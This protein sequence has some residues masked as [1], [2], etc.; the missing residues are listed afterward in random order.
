M[1]NHSLYLLYKGIVLNRWGRKGNI[2]LFLA[3]RCGSTVITDLLS[4][5][6]EVAW[7][8][9]I[10]NKN[11]MKY[12]IPPDWSR[13][14]VKKTILWHLYRKRIS[15]VGFETT[16]MPSQQLDP[17]IIGMTM[18][19]YIDLLVRIGITHFIILKRENHWRRCISAE[20]MRKKELSHT[21]ETIEKVTKLFVDIQNTQIGRASMPLLDIFKQTDER[22]EQLESILASYRTLKLTYEADVRDDPHIAYDKICNFL[23]IEKV[24]VETDYKKT[25]PF[26]LDQVLENS[27]EVAGLLKGTPYEWMLTD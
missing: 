22:Y 1:K 9:E 27:D 20:L 23:N 5:N 10:F 3:A 15:Y 8:K 4:K 16:I 19:N 2:A 11:N 21:R 26:P 24:P 6:P 18:E 13:N 17:K 12:Y 14:P 25:N 7:A